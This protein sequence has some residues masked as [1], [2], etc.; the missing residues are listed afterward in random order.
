MTF[1][2][3][4]KKPFNLVSTV[5]AI[6]SILLS[7]YFYFESLQ[8]REPYYLQHPSSQIYNKAVISPKI[9]VIDNV[10]KPVI[11]DVHVVELS[12]WNNG[13]TAIEPSDVRTPIFLEFPDGYRL[14]DSKVVKENKPA[15]TAF[16]ISDIPPS[17]T[18]APRVKLE[19]MHLD[20]GL[21][22]R[23]QFIYV[24]ESK[25]KLKFRGDIL[26]AEILDGSGFL[27]KDTSGWIGAV[28][29]VG[30]ILF[31]VFVLPN[32]FYRYIPNRSSLISAALG[33]SSLVV[34]LGFGIFIIW[35]LLVSKS[36]PI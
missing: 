2:S 30:I 4:L 25:P 12:F 34:S 21:G 10:G 32:F 7:I 20:P 18:N 8:K 31:S 19:W 6:F 9:T 1:L 26:D 35:L 29:I 24:G 13:K 11:G 3:E 28:A 33:V 14:L 22:A 5:I 27:A 17:E 23:L 16:K 36:V 15:V